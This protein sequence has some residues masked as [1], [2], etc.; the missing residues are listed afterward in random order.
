[1]LPPDVCQA[2]VFDTLFADRHQN[3]IR[4]QVQGSRQNQSV[5]DSG[6]AVGAIIDRG[7][8]MATRTL[9]PARSLL[10][11]RFVAAGDLA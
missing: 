4:A 10:R 6:L 11:H 7:L 9:A 1:M 5:G 3:S 8:L 2:T